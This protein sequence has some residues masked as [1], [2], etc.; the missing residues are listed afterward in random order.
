VR[1][2]SND[3]SIYSSY[4][5]RS[6]GIAAGDKYGDLSDGKKAGVMDAI[7]RFEGYSRGGN[8]SEQNFFGPFNGE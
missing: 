2:D 5:S 1:E 7:E 6:A 3:T 4:L 8:Y